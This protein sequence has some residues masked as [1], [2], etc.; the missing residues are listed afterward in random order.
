MAFQFHPSSQLINDQ[1]HRNEL[2]AKQLDYFRYFILP[3]AGPKAFVS[4][5]WEYNLKTI[6]ISSPKWLVGGSTGAIRSFAF[7]SGLVRK[8]NL[9]KELK[10][11]YCDMYYDNDSTSDTLD[12]FMQSLFQKCAPHES[13][14]QVLNH[15]DFKLAVMVTRVNPIYS[16]LPGFVFKG[17]LMATALGNVLTPRVVPLVFDRLC[18]Y[19]GESPPPC[20]KS[21]NIEFHKLTLKNAHQVL[22]ATTTIPFITKPCEFIDGIGNGI[23]LD[24]GLTDYY[25]NFELKNPSLP[26]LLLGDVNPHESLFRTMFDYYIPM[27]IP[28]KRKLPQNYFRNCSVVRPTSEYTGI[29]PKNSLPA[30]GDWFNQIYI[31]DPDKRKEFWNL[32]YSKSKEAWISSISNYINENGNDLKPGRRGFSF[33]RSQRE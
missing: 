13:L 19:T 33:R 29:L 11:I 6:P 27:W 32:A 25:L 30:V 9:T 17:V 4:S 3:A 28:W 14:E 31:Q 7:I 8:E 26:G 21:D 1:E 16:I 24:G 2:S 12:I 20:L 10:N 23:F 18:F 15:N 5:G 22:H